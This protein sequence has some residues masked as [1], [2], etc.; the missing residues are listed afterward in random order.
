[1]QKGPC[2]YAP[3]APPLA[4]VHSSRL[5]TVVITDSARLRLPVSGI[6]VL[7]R[8]GQ[9]L[10]GNSQFDING[11]HPCTGGT[12]SHPAP[13]RGALEVKGAVDEIGHAV[14]LPEPAGED[15]HETANG[16]CCATVRSP[17]WG[18]ASR[19]VAA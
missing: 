1:M 10:V 15:T 12:R 4:V 8:R 16:R 6:I 9:S 7:G 17:R 2:D 18:R 19:R 3:E 11:P 14:T 13:A 5:G